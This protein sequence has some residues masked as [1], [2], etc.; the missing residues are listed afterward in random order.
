VN[1][2]PISHRWDV[3]PKEAVRIQQEVVRRAIRAVKLRRRTRLIAGGDCAFDKQRGRAFAAWVLWHARAGEVVE[4]AWADVPMDFPYV[5][6]LLTFREGPALLAAWAKLS[7][8]PDLLMFDGNGYAHPRRCG[9]ASHL[10]VVLALPSIGVAK[11][12]LCGRADEPGPIRGDL[13]DLRDGDEVIARVLRTRDNVRPVFV[14]V[15]HRVTLD[16]AVRVTL[17]SGRGYRLPEP[18]RLADQLVGKVKRGE[19]K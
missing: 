5:P 6:G 9:L 7:A 16:D 14:S 10:G 18:T 12:R 8:D 17:E 19:V 1:R 13:A 3:T 2:T 11:S 15:G 4:Q